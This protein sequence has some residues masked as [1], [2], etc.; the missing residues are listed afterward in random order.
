LWLWLATSTAAL[1]ATIALD[2]PPGKPVGQSAAFMVESGPP[3]TLAQAEAAIG[4][5]GFQPLGAAVASFGIGHRPV[6]IHLAVANPTATPLQRQL[7]IGQSWLDQVDVHILSPDHPPSHY[8]LGDAWTGMPGLA[9]P[10]GFRV[11]HAFPPG[12]SALLIRIE[13]PDPM[14]LNLRLNT[15][16]QAAAQAREEYYGY[17]FLYG[18]LLSLT[19]YNLLLYLGIGRR[20][21][22]WYTL[23]LLSFIALNVA[24]TG[25]GAYWLWP[26]WPGFQRYVILCLMV[27]MPYAGLRFA[28]S[29]LELA[30]QAPRLDLGIRMGSGVA[31]SAI[32]I[33]ATLDTHEAAAWIA[34]V[35]VLV[36]ILAMVALGLYSVRKRWN[37]AWYFLFAALASALGTALTEF[38][39]WGFL[40]FHSVTYHGVE[41]GMMLDATILAL[42]LAYFVRL[43]MSQRERAEREARMDSLTRL[44]NRRGFQELAE[45]PFL[46]AR[47]HQR[48]LSALLLD[49]DHFKTINDRYGHAVGDQVLAEVAGFLAH[50][51]RRGDVVARW[52]G[53]EFIL[54]LPETG[55]DEAAQLAE[56]L[57]RAIQEMSIRR[58]DGQLSLTA[59]FG[60]AGLAGQASLMELVDMADQA[61]Y[62]AKAAGRNRVVTAPQS[63]SPSTPS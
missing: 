1:A 62:A 12:H 14:V 59:S 26:E 19:I 44:N 15:P 43:Q 49:I 3:L 63:P 56:R 22:L 4:G 11:E 23:Y 20:V 17:G 45:A 55:I 54:L 7:L 13:T 53:E 42:A 35:S 36:F 21:H 2:A 16:D 46:I 40:P 38:A 6:W 34:F 30:R 32:T 61:L 51:A 25:H 48:P 39:V 18:F 27:L 47:R 28:R 57:R 24:Y 33:A 58:E 41:L 31:L 5:P 37:G 29:F 52:G 60:V 10:Q 50:A 8:R 9:G